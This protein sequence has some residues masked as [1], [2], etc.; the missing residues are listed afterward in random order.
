M[1][2]IR[3]KINADYQQKKE[4][5]W[6]TGARVISNAQLAHLAANDVVDAEREK[7]AAYA[8]F[9]QALGV[10]IRTLM[11]SST[12]F[13]LAAAL[14]KVMFLFVIVGCELDYYGFIM[15]FASYWKLGLA[16][17]RL[18]LITGPLGYCLA[19]AMF[20]AYSSYAEGPNPST[21]R[22]TRV[23]PV[24]TNPVR[25]DALAFDAEAQPLPVLVYDSKEAIHLKYYHFMPLCR[26][27][28][29]IKDGNPSDVE[30]LFRVNS[31]SSFTL[32]IAQISGMTFLAVSGAPFDIFAKINIASQVINWGITFLYFGTSIAKRMKGSFKVDTLLY[33]S[34]AALRT[35]YESY[36]N[37]TQEAAQAGG[38]AEAKAKI[39]RFHES[40]NF[41]I[42][43]FVRQE[44]NLN[45]FSMEE[46]Y[47]MRQAI[48]KKMY[49]TYMKIK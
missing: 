29:V 14:P 12:S 21:E 30:G 9:E 11:A 32:G 19:I 6:E 5:A 22:S 2:A 15:A 28:L 25:P 3:S 24:G 26:Y 33:N 37:C 23:Q 16:P 42:S 34:T 49:S 44:I 13:G 40:L 18:I 46:K 17:L 43:E 39:N 20:L 8:V 48:R 4:D 36:L 35:E 31:L 38:G 41:E 1:Q 27:Y 7:K 45:A 10:D 47:K